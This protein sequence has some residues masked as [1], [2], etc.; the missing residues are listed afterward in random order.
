MI[1][2]ADLLAGSLVETSSQNPDQVCD[3]NHFL[4]YSPGG[5]LED[6]DL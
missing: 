1:V 5:N 2:V 4:S 6:F 3:D